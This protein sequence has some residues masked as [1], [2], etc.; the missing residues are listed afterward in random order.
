MRW[1]FGLP[2]RVVCRSMDQLGDGAEFCPSGGHSRGQMLK[3]ARVEEEWKERRTTHRKITLIQSP[4]I[5][6]TVFLGSLT[7][8]AS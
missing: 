4:E 6:S 3:D 1:L 7:K 5:T 8:R 2:A